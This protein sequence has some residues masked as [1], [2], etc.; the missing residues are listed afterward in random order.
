MIRS[1]RI[2]NFK[3]LRDTGVIRLRDLSVFIGNN[4]SGKS[5]VF[6]ALRFLQDAFRT[7]LA[8]AF[9]LY[10]GFEK[11]RHQQARL[12]KE[13]TTKTGFRKQFEPVVIDLVCQIDKHRYEYSIAINTTYGGDF[14]VVERESLKHNKTVVL[15]S[16]V[17]VGEKFN[18]V[19]YLFLDT[20]IQNDHPTGQV[21][22]A[23]IPGNGPYAAITFSQYV[24]GWQFLNLNAHLMGFP[25]TTDRLNP[26]VRLSPEGQN[27]AALVRQVARD[28]DRLNAIVDKMKYILPYASDIQTRTTADFEQKIELQLYEEGRQEPIPGWLFSSGTL[29]I[30]A[31]LAVMHQKE[32]PPVLLIDEIE[33]GLDPRTTALLMEELKRMIY[34]EG[35]QVIATTHSPYFLD[36]LELRHIIVTER[37]GD[38]VV[39]TRPDDNK[40]LD[41]WKEKFSPGRLYTMNRLTR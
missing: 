22:T 2:R 11:V 20:E 41:T 3:A 31:M 16:Q 24:Q 34:F 39:F 29:R 5:S 17:T 25:T 8:E 9:R 28:P 27:I 26:V 23:K 21:F 19:T 36:L 6:E 12:V 37:I 35:C 4:G 14:L 10:G 40:E 33:N 7:D 1:V 32:L 13:Q 38:K 18:A 15:D 30:L